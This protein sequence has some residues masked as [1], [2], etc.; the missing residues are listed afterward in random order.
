[1]LMGVR[2]INTNF[3]WDESGNG[4]IVSAPLG[5]YSDQCARTKLIII[6]KGIFEWEV[7][8]EKSCVYSWVG[9]CASENF[10]YGAFAGYQ[11][12]G[13]VLGSNGTCWNSGK[14][15][16]YC[17]PFGDGAKII[18]HLDVNKRTCAFISQWYKVSRSTELE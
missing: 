9:I 6:N 2:G 14:G 8:I 11:S 18:V 1:M 17:Q 15:S 3:A 5:N 10:N 16:N 4:K 13:W 7:I 12:T